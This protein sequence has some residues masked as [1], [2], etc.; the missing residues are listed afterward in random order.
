MRARILL[1]CISMV[2]R[3][4][5]PMGSEP[6][7]PTWP[8]NVKINPSQA[9]IN[10]VFATN[11]GHNPPDHGAFSAERYAF[12]FTPGSHA[13]D[14]P[15]GFYTTVHGLGKQPSETIFTS[16]KGIF[17]EEGDYNPTFGALNTFWRGAENFQTNG[18]YQWFAGTEGSGMLWALSQGTTLRRAIIEHDLVLFEY[19]KGDY[20]AGEASGGFMANVQING[21]VNSGSQQQWL[22]RNSRIGGWKDGV[23]NMVF[24]GVSGAPGDHCGTTTPPSSTIHPYLNVPTTP[25]IGEK[26]F[27]SY[28][29]G[30]F[31]LQI[32]SVQTNSQGT[33]WDV[34]ETVGF[35][36]VF[37]AKATDSVSIINSKLSAGLHVVFSPGIYN[38]T[39]PLIVK[40]SNQVL[41]GI[42]M[43]T[44]VS[45][46][47]NSVIEVASGVDGVRIGGFI[48]QAGSKHTPVLLKWGSSSN[49]TGYD[50]RNAG[51]PG[52]LYD[53]AGR[54]GG[55]DHSVVS[56]D[57]MVQ[58]NSGNV[59]GDN[60]WLWRADHSV[61]GPTHPQ[62][63]PC[64]TGLE[65]NGNNVIFY[66]LAVEH[67]LGDLVVWNGN[68]G[69][70]Y[71]FQA[72][73]PYGVTQASYGDKGYVA[74]RVGA[75]VTSHECYGAGIYHYF[76]DHAVTVKTGISCP[77][78]VEH[79]FKYP[80]GV[81]LNG[82]GTMNYII[83]NKGQK[84]SITS[85]TSDPGAHPA[86]FC[87]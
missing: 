71:M 87:G 69:K 64:T 70:V 15:L 41:L 44:L 74:Y 76:R 61:T 42:G 27:I 52:F 56:A 4:V 36:N 11:G 46:A 5:K 60:V 67:T 85:P 53:I 9:V 24:V 10:Q 30:K 50:S 62:D 43:A 22:T 31:Y 33:N 83:N 40:T 13:V 12:F 19:I 28:N 57:F 58:I 25:L 54:V 20:I 66:G 26:P 59:I 81:F 73:Y 38:L 68:G 65:V 79:S 63:N 6:N 86:W 72:E 7:P 2:L 48:I 8:V 32:P 75:H 3:Y 34:G 39:T 16:Q 21:H 49:N 47:G 29:G 23:W 78:A 82:L 17:C 51:N 37:V 14:V 1:V 18:N 45:G 84:T 55:P 80:L 35:E 77:S